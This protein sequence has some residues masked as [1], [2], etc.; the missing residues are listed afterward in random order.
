MELYQE[1]LG[2]ILQNAKIEIRIKSPGNIGRALELE[3]YKALQKIRNIIRNDTLTD[4]ECFLKIEEIITVFE[5]IGSH[6][7][8][9]HDWG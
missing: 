2:K 3:C 5:Q 7:E 4:N 8:G 9:R 1:M 6:A